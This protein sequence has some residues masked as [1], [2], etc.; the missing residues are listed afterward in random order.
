MSDDPTTQASESLRAAWDQLIARLDPAREAIESP[1]LHA[2]PPDPR[3]QG[4]SPVSRA[5]GT[6]IPAGWRRWEGR[7]ECG[8]DRRGRCRR[9]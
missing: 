2:P 3:G 6:P 7:F 9:R 4:R 5:S 1:E 8:A